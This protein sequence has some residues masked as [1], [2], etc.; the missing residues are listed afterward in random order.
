[1]DKIASPVELADQLRKI[2]AYAQSDQPSRQKLAD[3]L[4]VLANR[5]AANPL[6]GPEPTPE[7]LQKSRKAIEKLKALNL[8][9]RAYSGRGMYGDYCVGVT[10]THEEAKQIKKMFGGAS[11][12]SMGMGVIVYWRQFP[13]PPGLRDIKKWDEPEA[14]SPYLVTVLRETKEEHTF[15]VE[16]DSVEGAEAEALEMAED[17]RAGWLA[18]DSEY[19]VTRVKPK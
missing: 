15:E 2:L 9:P 5:V 12:D 8:G 3:S 7:Q 14:V 16:S 13:W 4:E 11:L 18:M 17:Q 10:V 6:G 1:M 19:K